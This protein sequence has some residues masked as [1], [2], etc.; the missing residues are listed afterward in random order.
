MLFQKEIINRLKD[1]GLNSYE[2]RLWIALL[3]RGVSTAGELSDIADVPRSRSYDVLESLE[4]KGFII[5]KLGKPIKYI[6]VTPAEV[7]NRVKSTVEKEAESQFKVLENLQKS[8]F[9]DE[10]DLLY[11]N[12]INHIEPV[13]MT[14]VVKGRPNMFSHLSYM[15]KNAK[16]SVALSTTEEGFV[17]ESKAL[18]N[19]LK[20]AKENGA[21]I[22]IVTHLSK[23]SQESYDEIKPIAAIRHVEGNPVRMCIVDGEQAFMTLLHDAD[24]HP[25]YDAGVCVNTKHAGENFESYFESMWSKGQ[26][27]EKF[28]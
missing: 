5:M 24:V 8:K 10:L 14:G 21:K 6:A 7:I 3:S 9:I 2:A 28:E 17:R 13:D 20:K 11:S 27:K 15:I 26:T 1:I 25:S 4:K 19:A 22:R 18:R 12:G 16:K 23:I